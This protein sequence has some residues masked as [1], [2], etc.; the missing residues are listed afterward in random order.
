MTLPQFVQN[1]LNP[2][3]PDR[4]VAFREARLAFARGSTGADSLHVFLHPLAEAVEHLLQVGQANQHDLARQA[5][6]RATGDHLHF[7]EGAFPGRQLRE[8]DQITG[9]Q[10]ALYARGR[11]RHIER[12]RSLEQVDSRIAGGQY[13]GKHQGTTILM[14]GDTEAHLLAHL[15]ADF[16]GNLYGH[17]TAHRLLDP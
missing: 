17:R 10:E 4:A 1:M 6:A 5:T 9:V 7:G 2:R 14:H 13:V 8:T 15:L 12:L 11:L 3:C 16:F